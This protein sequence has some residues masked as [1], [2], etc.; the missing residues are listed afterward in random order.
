MSILNGFLKT[1]RYRKTSDGYIRQSEWTKSDTV[2][3][4]DG[5]TLTQ[6]MQDIGWQ[7]VNHEHTNQTL[8]P[9]C[10]E[11]T[12]GV[13][14][15]GYLDFHYDN[16]SEDYTSRI[17]EHSAGVLTIDA[18]VI[19]QGNMIVNAS[20]DYGATKARNTVFITEDPGAGS[21]VSYGNGSVICVY[22]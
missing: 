13:G 4:D 20:N 1:I 8:R 18:S 22:E 15:G 19:L 21:S 11:F 7:M 2:E 16:S 17:A 6:R 10:L 3:M 14:H 9:V 5:E 12:S